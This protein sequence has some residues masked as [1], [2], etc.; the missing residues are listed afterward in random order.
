VWRPV[1]LVLE[2]GVDD[3]DEAGGLE[4]IGGEEAGGVDLVPH[5]S[6]HADVEAEAETLRIS[7]METAYQKVWF[8]AT[9]P[10]TCSDFRAK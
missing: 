6:K 7:Q 10:F 1:L 8:G 3:E 9:S 5:L 4:A 2:L